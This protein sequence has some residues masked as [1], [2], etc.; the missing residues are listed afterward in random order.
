MKKAKKVRRIVL[1]VGHPWFFRKAEDI[2][3]DA[4]YLTEGVG[5]GTSVPFKFKNVGNWN[6]CRLVLEVIK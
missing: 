3:F 5:T 1:A 4:V 6:K 2:Y